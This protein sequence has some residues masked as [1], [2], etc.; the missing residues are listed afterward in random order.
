MVVERGEKKLFLEKKILYRFVNFKKL[1]L[2]IYIY[3]NK[4]NGFYK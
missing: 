2:D 4:V 1:V 3:M